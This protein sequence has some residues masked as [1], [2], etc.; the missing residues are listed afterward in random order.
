MTISY[1]TIPQDGWTV[2]TEN[3]NGDP[4]KNGGNR[5][6]LKVESSKHIDNFTIVIVARVGSYAD[7]TEG[8]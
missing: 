5:K 7:K 2:Y 6:G 8:T 1:N 3:E 4:K